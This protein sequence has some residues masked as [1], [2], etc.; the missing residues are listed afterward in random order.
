MG[1]TTRTARDSHAIARE[2]E[3]VLANYGK[4]LQSFDAAVRSRSQLRM[5]R[6][7]VSTATS[8]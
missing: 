3:C 1:S 4:A 8:Q 6:G 7:Q 2:L 5:Q